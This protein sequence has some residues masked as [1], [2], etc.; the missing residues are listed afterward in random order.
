MEKMVTWKGQTYYFDPD[1]SK[2][3]DLIYFEKARHEPQ[4]REWLQ[5]GTFGKSG[6]DPLKYVRLKNMSDEH[7]EACLRTQPP[8]Y[9]GKFYTKA[10]KT[11]LKFRKNHPEFSVADTF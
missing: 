1:H 5:W 7:I 3:T 4:V 8:A 9:L 11:E 10:F 6:Q 2:R